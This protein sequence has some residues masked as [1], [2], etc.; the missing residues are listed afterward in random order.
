MDEGSP[1]LRVDHPQFVHAV[2]RVEARL[3]APVV[4]EAG[5]RDLDR[6]GD[7]VRD[8]VKRDFRSGVRGGVVTTPAIFELGGTQGSQAE[9]W[10]WNGTAWTEVDT[11][12]P[13]ILGIPLMAVLNGTL[14]AVT[15][16]PNAMSPTADAGSGAGDR[17]V[18]PDGQTSSPTRA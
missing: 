6:R 16:N 12:G 11:E 8:R 4:G 1:P 2:T 3:Q 15:A 17:S 14:V 5:R 9:T 7:P 13:T 18:R 10:T